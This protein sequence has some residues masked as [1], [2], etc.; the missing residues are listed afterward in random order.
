M[1]IK[2]VDTLESM[3]NFPVANASG[4]QFSDGEDLQKKFD[5]GSLGGGAEAYTEL[6]QEEYDALSDDEKSSGTE[7][8][9]YDTG[10]IYKYGVLYGEKKPVEMTFKAYKELE[11]AGGVEVDTDYI[12][13]GNESGVLLDSNDIGHGDGTVKTKIDKID[14]N[15]ADKTDL[16][17]INIKQFNQPGGSTPK[18]IT[19]RT[20]GVGLGGIELNSAYA[21]KYMFSTP[22][23]IPVYFGGGQYKG[24]TLNGWFWADGGKTLYLKIS[25]YVPFSISVLGSL[26]NDSLINN[27]TT[28]SDL[29]FT[30]PEGVTF[31]TALNDNAT[32][33]DVAGKAD[34]QLA[35]RNTDYL[36]SDRPYLKIS[37]NGSL[38]HVGYYVCETYILC[39]HLGN[40]GALSFIRTDSGASCVYK[41]I[42]GTL[43]L[44][45]E[46]T[47]EYSCWLK[48]S[49]SSSEIITVYSLNGYTP[50]VQAVTST[51]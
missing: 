25:G 12:I 24:Y 34:K 28:I 47:N 41:D 33:N 36:K 35:V 37:R 31:N 42:V 48:Y 51:T 8:R 10:H 7:Y 13:I 27:V 39:N 21:G 43:S 2:L 45:V 44:S 46:K 3:G 9:T 38:S 32:Y 1:S 40:M 49:S 17:K 6:S 14:E 15:K 50:T 5:D 22:N 16:E 19:I 29:S 20:T 11:E 18:Y 30:A 4:I 26:P 23:S